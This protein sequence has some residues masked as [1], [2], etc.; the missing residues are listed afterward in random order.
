MWINMGQVLHVF[1]NAKTRQCVS[2]SAHVD[3]LAPCI[4]KHY[5]MRWLL[6]LLVQPFDRV[7]ELGVPPKF[8][9]VPMVCSF[10]LLTSQ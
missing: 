1:I 6:V 4:L 10:T 2:L 9:R 7:S 3:Y 8:G 5:N